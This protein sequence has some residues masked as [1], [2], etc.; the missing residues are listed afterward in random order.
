[1]GDSISFKVT[2]N[3]EK[4]R[5]YEL[6]G[7]DSGNGNSS[8]KAL[9]LTIA[10]QTFEIKVGADGEETSDAHSKSYAFKLVAT[11]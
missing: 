8:A 9:T 1:M 5:Q 11:A 6:D 7:L 4:K 2:Y 10:G 3:F